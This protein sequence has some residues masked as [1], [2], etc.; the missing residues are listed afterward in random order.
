[1]NNISRKEDELS[2][3]IIEK[4]YIKTEAST[5]SVKPIKFTEKHVGTD[6]EKIKELLEFLRDNLIIEKGNKN[7]QR[8]HFNLLKGKP[9]GSYPKIKW[10]KDIGLYKSFVKNVL[11]GKGRY[12]I[13]AEIFEVS[14]YSVND[15]VELRNKHKKTSE[16]TIEVK[17]LKKALQK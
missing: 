2:Q 10:L 11:F 15:L 13:A 1:L 8:Y 6:E 16:I 14:G 3:L 17:M 7:D 12:E 4:N 5:L 9:K